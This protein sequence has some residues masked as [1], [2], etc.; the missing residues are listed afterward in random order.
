MYG[1]IKDGDL[2][3]NI[4][5]DLKRKYANSFKLEYNESEILVDFADTNKNQEY[6][7]DLVSMVKFSPEMAEKFV[8]SLVELIMEYNNEFDKN[9]LNLNN[10]DK[11]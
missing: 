8:V 5:D 9:L 2:K 10:N 4:P 7:L 3:I 6:D 1:K 11:E